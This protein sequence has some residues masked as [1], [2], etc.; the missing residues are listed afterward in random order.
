MLDDTTGLPKLPEGYYW[1]ITDTDYQDSFGIIKIMRTRID[2]VN[3]GILSS[4]RPLKSG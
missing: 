1:K 4:G 3:K 2:H